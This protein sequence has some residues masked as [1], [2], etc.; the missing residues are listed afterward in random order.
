MIKLTRSNDRDVW[1]EPSA[2]VMVEEASPIAGR[3]RTTITLKS[4]S[5]LL[6]KEDV[7]YILAERL[8]ARQGVVEIPLRDGADW[9]APPEDIASYLA[10]C[11]ELARQTTMRSG[12]VK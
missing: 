8:K 9:S 12:F 6:V 11:Q 1:V 3:E 10:E 7:Q 5:I 2:I 4:G